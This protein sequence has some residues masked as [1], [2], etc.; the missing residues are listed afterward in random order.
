MTKEV[1]WEKNPNSYQNKTWSKKQRQDWWRDRKWTEGRTKNW[2]L[3]KE[4]RNHKTYS[5]KI[6]NHGSIT[7]APL[8]PSKEIP[9]VFTE[10]MSPFVLDFPWNWKTILINIKRGSSHLLDCWP[11]KNFMSAMPADRRLLFSVYLQPLP[12]S[13][14]SSL[15]VRPLTRDFTG[16]FNN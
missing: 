12:P 14:N 8:Q 5:Q 4:K 2:R 10:F 16:D 7:Q 1:K 9:L 11:S 15:V 3:N 6:Q 13:L